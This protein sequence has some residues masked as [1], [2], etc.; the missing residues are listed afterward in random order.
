[1]LF[2]HNTSRLDDEPYPDLLKE[3]GFTGFPTLAFM[4]DEGNVLAKPASRT[5][6]SYDKTLS[7]VESVLSLK[8]K[9]EA[10]DTT[11]INALFVAELELG[12]IDY[13]DAKTRYAA[14]ED[15]SDPDCIRIEAKLAKMEAKNLLASAQAALRAK[16][17]DEAAALYRQATAKDPD[18]WRA[19]YFLGSV[20][21]SDK[22]Y[23]EAIKVNIKVAGMDSPAKSNA[24]YNV[25]CA[26]AL[27]G[28]KDMAFEWL[29]K[30]VEAGFRNTRT[31]EGDSD[32]DSLRED[33]RFPEVLAAVAEAAEAARKKRK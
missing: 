5:V 21:Q 22:K 4:D 23:E 29:N 9:A 26:Y 18:N 17:Y 16:D 25:A 24:G 28:K 3:K 8:A 13:E 19:W 31:I 27:L 32:M 15:V 30:A 33:P 12:Q 14:L 10:G 7:L 6:E 1:M 11:V 20:L 2:L